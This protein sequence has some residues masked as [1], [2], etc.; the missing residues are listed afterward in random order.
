MIKFQNIH[1]IYY[2][3]IVALE[4]VSF[5][6]KESVDGEYKEVYKTNGLFDKHAYFEICNTCSKD[7][8][9]NLAKDSVYLF[10]IRF[11]MTV[12]NKIYYSNEHIIDTREDSDYMT[13]KCY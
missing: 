9:F 1:K 7:A 4:D 5:E 6:V 3:N 13:K 10:R 12:L 8:D 11:N 2:P